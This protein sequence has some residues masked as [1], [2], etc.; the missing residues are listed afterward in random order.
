MSLLRFRDRSLLAHVILSIVFTESF[1]VFPRTLFKDQS[2]RVQ[3]VFV[4]KRP[5]DCYIAQVVIVIVIVV[6]VV[7]VTTLFHT[8]CSL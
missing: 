7:V 6:V 1:N 5:I 2:S 4:I 8:V 3:N